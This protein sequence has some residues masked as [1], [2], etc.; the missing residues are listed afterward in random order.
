MA[1]TVPWIRLSLLLPP[2]KAMKALTSLPQFQNRMY[3][4]NLSHWTSHHAHI[5][6]S[7]YTRHKVYGTA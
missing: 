6:T 7:T 5:I 2:V 1:V 3:N 4:S